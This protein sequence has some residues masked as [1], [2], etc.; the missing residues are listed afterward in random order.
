VNGSGTFLTQWG[1][2]S[3]DALAWMR[4]PADSSGSQG[5]LVFYAYNTQMALNS[6]AGSYP[7]VMGTQYDAAGRVTER[8]LGNIALQTRYFYYPWNTPEQG[9]RLQQMTSGLLLDLDSLQDLRYT[10]DKTGNVLTIQ[11]Y[12]VT[13]PPQ[14][15]TFTYDNLN[16]L[17]S[18]AASGGL[19]GLYSESYTY[20]PGTGNLASKNGASY[21]YDDA[22]HKHAV[23]SVPAN[24]WS[25]QYDAN[26]DMTQRV[27]GGTYNL[28]YDAE[29][30]LTGVS[31]A[32]TANYL[33]DGDGNRI[34]ATEGVTTTV[35]IGSYF[36]WT[37]SVSTMKKYYYAGAVRVAM[38]VG[39][40]APLWLLGDHLGSTS[41]VA[42][43]NGTPYGEKR[44]KAWGETRFDQG[45]TPTTL[46]YTGQ[47][48]EASLGLYYYGARWY[49]P[50]LGRFIQ[51]D[52]VVSHP[53]NSQSWDRYAYVLNNPV[54][55]TDSSG[56]FVDELVIGVV[57]IVIV[58]VVAI[59]PL[60]TESY[61]NGGPEA[62]GEVLSEF[63]DWIFEPLNDSIKRLNDLAAFAKRGKAG[64]AASAA[65]HLAMLLKRT[66][67]G[68][69]AHPGSP[70]PEGRDKNTNMKG[71]WNDLD[72]LQRNLKNSGKNLQKFLKG[73]NWTDD[74]IEDFIK[75]LQD[76]KDLLRDMLESGELTQKEYNDWLDLIQWLL[77]L[78][79]RR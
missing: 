51:A 19:G 35:Y 17:L 47:R 66:V 21:A 43:N 31:G 70:D 8:S 68:F 79:N 63:L 45:I 1:Y 72:N 12:V 41:R 37:G 15:Q 52:T 50:E 38:R 18:A 11:D 30:R 44:Y 54:I 25:F 40:Q 2:N 60:I 9:G 73:K 55:Y 75:S 34:R 10:Y 22:N 3:A 48:Q 5:E 61:A 26:G 78:R 62:F 65:Q 53:L 77:G 16:R 42:N 76:F 23:T 39:S 56:H 33:Y 46:R 67:A 20:D 14:T 64:G 69:G 74:M 13:N 28:S 6:L 57:I 71:L 7:Y 29:N 59:V 36:E 27:K 58:L 32:A 49:D 24:G 4:Y